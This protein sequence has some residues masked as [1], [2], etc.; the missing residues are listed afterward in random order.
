MQ[1]ATE[2]KKPFSIWHNTTRTHVWIEFA[3]DAWR[4]RFKRYVEKFEPL[5][6]PQQGPPAG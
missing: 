5:A 4:V 2:A 1:R 3:M 6:G